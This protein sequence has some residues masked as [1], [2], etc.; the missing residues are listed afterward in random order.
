MAVIHHE[1]LGLFVLQTAKMDYVIHLSET[2]RLTH[3]YWGD[4]L[5]YPSDYPPPPQNWVLA[6]QHANWP[7]MLAELP[8]L[9]GLQE[10]SPL[11]RTTFADGTR[12]LRLVCHSYKIAENELSFELKDEFYNLSVTARYQVYPDCNLFKRRL[13]LTNTG[14]EIIK[15]EDA[16]SGGAPLS[17]DRGDNFRL[18]HLSGAWAA[19]TIVEQTALTGGRKVIEGR[20]NLTGHAHNPFIAIDVNATEN[21]GEVWFAAL[22]WS[23]N[24]RL[25]VEQIRSPFKLTRLG[26][27]LND[28]EFG[29]QLESGEQFETPWLA[30]GYSSNGFGEM[31]RNL[32]RY[33]RRYVLPENFR[34]ELRPVL[35]N[36]WEA[37]TFNV[38]EAEQLA[39][40][41]KAAKL[42][43]EV[44]VVDDGWFGERHHDR[45]GL[46]DWQP[47]AGKFPNGLNP[48]IQKVNELGM[49]F[50]LWF[51]PEMVNPD[52]DLYR[53]H[54]DWVYHFPNR[55]RT[56]SRNQLILNLAK[57]AVEEFIFNMLDD[58]LARHNITYVKWDYNRIISEAGWNDAPAGRDREFW[59]RHVQALYRI[60][61]KLRE[62][63][64]KVL[65]E[66][67]ASGGGRADLGALHHYDHIWTSDNTDPLDRLAI[68]HGYSLAYAPKTMYCWVTETN[69][70]KAN[71]SLR[72]RFHSSFMGS[73]GVGSSL[74]HF[75]E[76]ELEEAA[77]LVA[78][79]K[80]FRHVVQHGD[81]YRL[82]PLGRLEGVLAVQYLSEDRREAVVLAYGYR[83][84]FW[85]NSTRLQ[86]RDLLPEGIYRVEGEL[87]NESGQHLSGQIL[88]SRG[89]LPKLSQ[90][91]D[92]AVVRLTLETPPA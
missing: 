13:E 64:P 4:R 50:G 73:L 22:E 41:E 57:P 11:L 24:W 91:I 81:F 31:S 63:H 23:G 47:N 9:G 34:Q 6:S 90:G 2:G 48:L 5:P 10:V 1:N 7:D 62:R 79:Y 59:V 17:V 42:G 84:H 67:C 8:T 53:A 29:W 60:L 12:D 87:W 52:S 18:T 68:Q 19:E 43:S 72:Y 21:D 61:D 89:I 65:F 69:H 46:G 82:T 25:F 45:A 85:Q 76:A 36:S 83:K 56:E 44:F 32:H 70:N 54:P 30:L 51:E 16:L 71:F 26:G 38:N 33:Q 66:G 37:V 27:G 77:K 28:F 15:I 80:E 92:S 3:V 49:Q 78:E 14:P 86:L 40:A 39:L 75:S 88:M 58:M 74:N 35:Y 20:Q 55:P